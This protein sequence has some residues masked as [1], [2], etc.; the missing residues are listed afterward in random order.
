MNIPSQKPT[1]IF[2][3][4]LWSHQR[5]WQG[6]A[7]LLPGDAY[8]LVADTTNRK[9]SLLMKKVARLLSQKGRLVYTWEPAKNHP[10]KF[11]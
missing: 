11:E 7:R 5:L 10:E 4:A 2:S 1:A 3:A 6:A 8:L 9:Q